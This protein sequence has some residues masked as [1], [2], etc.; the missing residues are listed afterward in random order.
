MGSPAEET[1]ATPPTLALPTT[2]GNVS[3][4]LSDGSTIQASY[5]P[6]TG[7]WTVDG[8]EIGSGTSIGSDKTIVSW[9]AIAA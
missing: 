8:A 3:L 6:V 5:N 9:S 4:I 1:T 2:E 7:K